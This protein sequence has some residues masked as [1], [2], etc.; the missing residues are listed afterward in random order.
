M[1][2]LTVLLMKNATSLLSDSLI[3]YAELPPAQ[4]RSVQRRIKVQELKRMHKGVATSLPEEDWP[5]LVEQHRLRLLAALHPD[6]VIG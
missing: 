1:A 5:R 2:K 3:L 4:L 6:T